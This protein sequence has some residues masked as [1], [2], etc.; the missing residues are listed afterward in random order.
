MHRYCATGETS[1]IITIIM[2]WWTLTL[3]TLRH[4]SFSL[5]LLQILMINNRIKNFM[6]Q[7]QRVIQVINNYR[8]I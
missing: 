4:A 2:F 3:C 5:K 7:M 1:K 6:K 8:F